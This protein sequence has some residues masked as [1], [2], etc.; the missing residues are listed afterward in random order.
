MGDVVFGVRH[1]VERGTLY[2]VA[3]V[4]ANAVKYTFTFHPAA[5]YVIGNGTGDWTDSNPD[6]EM[7]PGSDG[8]WVSPAFTAGGEMRAYIKVP[9]YDWWKTEF[10]L[11]K[12]KELYFRDFDIPANWAE[13]AGDK[14]N[15]PDPENYSVAVSAGQKLYVNFSDN[16]GEVK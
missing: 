4:G 6:W 2:V 12:G 15:K 3:E 9:G 14:G 5:A 11:Y 16:T 8:K 7:K 10:T 13:N 1:P